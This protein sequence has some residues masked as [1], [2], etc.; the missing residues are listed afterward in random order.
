[1]H[2]FLKWLCNEEKSKSQ[3]KQ[4]CTDHADVSETNFHPNFHT[5]IL[6]GENLDLTVISNKENYNAKSIHI[7][8]YTLNKIEL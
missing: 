1:M 7:S 4:D 3:L 2:S 8:S 5:F 6:N